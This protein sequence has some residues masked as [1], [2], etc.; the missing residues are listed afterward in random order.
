M[1]TYR[2]TTRWV[3]TLETPTE[4]RGWRPREALMLLGS[5]LLGFTAMFALTYGGLAVA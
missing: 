3:A 5:A 2:E 4:S 1:A